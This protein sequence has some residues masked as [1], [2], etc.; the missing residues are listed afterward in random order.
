MTNFE[1]IVLAVVEGLTEFLPVS[2]TGHM[3]VASSL[4]GIHQDAFTKLFEVAIQFGTILS[5]VVLYAKKFFDFKRLDFYVKLI[6]AVLPALG[7]GFLLADKIDALLESPT[8]V[9]IA[10][11]LGGVIFLFVDR[12]FKPSKVHSEEAITPLKGFFIGCWQCVAMIPGVSRSAASIIGGLQQGL[13]RKVAA[14]F[15]FFL[16]V[17]TMAA[18]TG[19]KLL[20]AYLDT[21]EMLS[22]PANLQALAIGNVVGFLVAIAA[23]KFFIGFVQKFG[24]KW[25]GWYRIVAGITILL[26]I[27]SG[28]MKG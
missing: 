26:L 15:S 9:A 20:K 17:P 10:L 24:F 8:V 28:F 23:I 22:N 13:D 12:I 3:V 25:F 6:I 16:A 7:L 14:E 2:S 19:Y 5:V 11:I 18:A 4:M 1:A 21:P 27:F